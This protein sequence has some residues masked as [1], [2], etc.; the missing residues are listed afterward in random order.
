[1][2]VRSRRPASSSS[3]ARPR[4]QSKETPVVRLLQS[5]P[6]LRKPCFEPD[7]RGLVRTTRSLHTSSWFVAARHTRAK[8]RKLTNLP[9]RAR[10]VRQ[11]STVFR[12]KA[13]RQCDVE[14]L[15]LLH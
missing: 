8:I 2:R 7:I 4:I 13:E 11:N 15:Q 3:T 5:K 6:T 12:S 1:M 14:R 9:R 10:V